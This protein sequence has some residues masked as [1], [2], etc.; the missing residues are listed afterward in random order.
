MEEGFSA[1]KPIERMTLEEFLRWEDR[2]DTHYELIGGSP[3]AM[4]PQPHCQKLHTS[5][6]SR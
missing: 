2:T 4:A 3:M 1:V 5:Y 6:G